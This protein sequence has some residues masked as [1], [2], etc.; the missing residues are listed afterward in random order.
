MKKTH[1]KTRPATGLFKINA[2]EAVLILSGGIGAFFGFPN[3]F[4]QLPPLVVMWPLCVTLLALEAPGRAK[5]CLSTLLCAVLGYSLSLYWL[6]YPMCNYGGVPWPLAVVLIIMLAIVLSMFTVVYGLVVRKF[7]RHMPPLPFFVSSALA[8]GALELMRGWAFSGFPWLS[9][10]SAFMGWPV[11]AQAASLFGM[12]GLSAVYVLT[13]LMFLPLVTAYQKPMTLAPGPDP[14]A[15][16]R[17]KKAFFAAGL[18]MLA[19]SAVY[20][21]IRLNM[22]FTAGRPVT[23]VMAQGNVEQAQKWDADKQSDTVKHYIS[24]SLQG[25]EDAKKSGLGEAE[26]VIWPETSVPFFFKASRELGFPIRDLARENNVALLF[27]APARAARLYESGIYNRVWLL[28][29]KGQDLAYYDKE[30]LVPFGEYLPLNVYIPF[31]VEFMQGWGFSQ[32]TNQHPLNHGDIASG[33]L[34]CYEAI[35]PELA[36]ARVKNGA[37][38]LVNVSNDAWFGDSAAPVQHLQQAAMR[39]VEQGRYMARATNTGISAFIDPNGRIMQASEIFADQAL[40]GQVRLLAGT[41]FYHDY[42]KV[43]NIILGFTPA[44]LLGWAV[45]SDIIRKR[46]NAAVR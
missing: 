37:N 38:L 32:G 28:G 12:Y 1:K 10:S 35:F 36:Q 42:Y 7:S 18:A 17:H 3:P 25:I 2:R 20:G 16:A 39:A 11:L 30:H 19:L 40:H 46:K 6:M 14:A 33:V 31:A 13:A 41:T 29:E 9:L 4:V 8:W 21:T 23:L 15:A 43:I 24:L 5:A 44:L 34:I 22:D 45:I 27:G 26:M